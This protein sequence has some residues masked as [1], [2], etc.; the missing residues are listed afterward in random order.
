MPSRTFSPE[1]VG[2]ALR[3]TS[4]ASDNSTLNYI[5]TST[6][7][8]RSSGKEIS[9]IMPIKFKGDMTK[10]V[11]KNKGDMTKT[12]LRKRVS[13]ILSGGSSGSSTNDIYTK[14]LLH[15]DDT[16]TSSSS[17]SAYYPFRCIKSF[18]GTKLYVGTHGPDTGSQGIHVIDV[19]TNTKIKTISTTG[20]V[21]SL[22]TNS[23][24]T[25]I[26]RTNYGVN[27]SSNS[28]STVEVIDTSNDAVL[29]TITVGSSTM[30][31]AITPDD[32]FL[33]VTR[34]YGGLYRIDT[35]T[36]TLTDLGITTAKFSPIISSDGTK[37]IVNDSTSVYC[38]SINK[39]TG[40][41]TLVT[42]LTG[43]TNPFTSCSDSTNVY[44]MN[45]TTSG[46]VI[47]VSWS[48]FTKG[49]AISV[50]QEPYGGSVSSDGKLYVPNVAGNTISVIDTATL[51]VVGTL[52]GYTS[53][54]DAIVFGSKLFVANY[55]ASGSISVIDQASFSDAAP[56]AIKQ[57]KFG[58]VTT[59]TAQSKF[60]GKSLAL[61]GTNTNKLQFA[62][63]K[64][65]AMDFSNQPFCVEG[66]FYLN[67][68]TG[69]S[70]LFGFANSDTGDWQGLHVELDP[71]NRFA[72]YLTT[73]GAT[74]DLGQPG[75]STTTTPSINSWFHLA[76]TRE[77]V[78]GDIKLF[79]NGTLIGTKSTTA[80]L[81]TGDYMQIGRT[82]YVNATRVNGYVD[83]FRVVVGSC[84][85][86]ASAF[87]VPTAEL[88]ATAD[89]KLLIK[90]STTIKD[91]SSLNLYT[92]ALGSAASSTVQSK[93]GGSSIK[94]A[95]AT[96]DYVRV[97]NNTQPIDLRDRD[98]TIEGWFY[99]N[100]K[101]VGYQPLLGMYTDGDMQGFNMCHESGSGQIVFAYLANGSWGSLNSGVNADTGSWH[102]IA[103]TRS[104]TSLRFFF[105]GQLKATNTLAAGA[106]FA[107]KDYI[108][109]GYYQHLP[110]G[111][112]TFNGYIDEVRIL[113]EKCAYATNFTPQTTQH[114][115]G[116]N[117]G[118]PNTAALT[119]SFTNTTLPGLKVWYKAD[120][121]TGLADGASVTS[122]V[123]SSGNGKSLSG[124]GAIYQATGIN[125]R[126]IVYFNG[127]GNLTA[128][129]TGLPTGNPART[130]Y[131]VG[132]KG[133]TNANQEMWGWGDNSTGRVGLW[134][135]NNAVCYESMG[136]TTGWYSTVVGNKF[137]L[138]HAH[139]AGEN[140]TQNPLYANGVPT[141]MSATG[142]ANIG[143]STIAVGHIP[144]YT[145]ALYWVGGCAE[146]LVFDRKHTNS[147]RQQVEAYLAEKY[148][149][150]V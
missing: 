56:S 29:S 130:V 150:S 66:W 53:P 129:N 41:L 30:Y 145:D 63:P 58:T 70:W 46:T 96:G 93:F 108:F 65:K 82:N 131:T 101:N 118:L 116:A 103:V 141:T 9:T 107:S 47:P 113:V 85:Y 77:T 105:N 52:T 74:W 79:H 24:G 80:T 43:F 68:L 8:S 33:Y 78:G 19:A 100:Q 110:G 50:G 27:S 114:Q 28:G 25:R 123:D 10:V 34:E 21:I 12:T 138:T 60:G 115:L 38:Y 4:F 40:G 54:R 91:E 134:W 83:D 15:F 124:T 64:T 119:N 149:I 147:E 120:S 117:I 133:G 23:T 3:R 106:S 144:G 125:G 62:N 88:T 73:N 49:T 14:M 7:L 55:T 17:I 98:F 111:A 89:T 72:V 102:H 45:K 104:G 51:K 148:G 142:T 16:T 140:L 76:L 39:T 35:A 5:Y 48:T 87:V 42:T 99:F 1:V 69:N 92:Q 143:T 132:Y 71:S 13:Q 36:L 136:P 2:L 121:I 59:S 127:S 18:D 57:F 112:K 95:S 6:E 122:W 75:I 139:G 84:P 81:Y 137:I 146:I 44:V 32:K 86:S 94:I 97:Y 31:I 20:S 126:P 128:T 61:D 109:A 37:L 11:A 135:G 26:Y 67:S 90:G 22:V